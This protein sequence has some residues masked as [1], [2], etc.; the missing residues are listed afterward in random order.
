MG[1]KEI[2]VETTPC[3]YC[4]RPVDVPVVKWT[5]K[6]ICKYCR[7]QSIYCGRPNLTLIQ[8]AK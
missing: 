8:G 1:T 5:G 3:I 2:K 6:F 4:G 7:L